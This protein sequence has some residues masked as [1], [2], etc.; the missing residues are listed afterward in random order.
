MPN[1]RLVFLLILPVAATACESQPPVAATPPPAAQ[2]SAEVLMQ[3]ALTFKLPPA[4]VAPAAPVEP[5][6]APISAAVE[7]KPG[8]TSGVGKGG[9]AGGGG[10]G[11]AD[12]PGTGQA[13]GQSSPGPATS[14]SGGA[15]TLNPIRVSA[16][17][18]VVAMAQPAA[19]TMPPAKSRGQ[20]RQE[21]LAAA[22]EKA[23]LAL[24]AIPEAVD[25]P[26]KVVVKMPDNLAL[27]ETWVAVQGE[28]EQSDGGHAPD[29]VEGGYTER[30]LSF[31]K[32]GILTIRQKHG[33]DR[34]LTRTMD[35]TLQ[36]AGKMQ[37]G[38]ERR[39]DAFLMAKTRQAVH[40]ASGEYE[41]LPP[42][43][44]FPAA[45]EVMVS[46]DKASVTLDGKVYRRAK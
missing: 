9:M 4:K 37:V 6:V 24:A 14:A 20:A 16:P 31:G 15:V 28:W 21:E 43:A 10:R 19:P 27:Q 3:Q 1:F 5:S 8:G 32:D 25:I 30:K 22:K 36:S 34:T 39:P 44:G 26:E 29:C 46:E 38:K 18:P 23:K 41:I 33:P 13:G 7:G 42:S 17:P 45:W 35:Y 40:G 11:A 2:P 12:L